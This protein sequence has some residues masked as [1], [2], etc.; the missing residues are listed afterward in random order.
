MFI[1]TTQA[2]VF[3][4]RNKATS[5][6]PSQWHGAAARIIRNCFGCAVHTPCSCLPVLTL[7]PFF[8]R[9]VLP[10]LLPVLFVLTVHFV[11]ALAS[12]I[13][14]MTGVLPSGLA[15]QGILITRS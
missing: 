12:L 10:F 15:P 9:G 6:Q 7:T 5:V 2:S 4:D 1:L 14:T 3:M 13:G 8:C 11:S